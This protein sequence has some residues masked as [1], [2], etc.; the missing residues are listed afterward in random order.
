MN[1]SIGKS[2]K[3]IGGIIFAVLVFAMVRAIFSANE[4]EE[5]ITPSTQST[6]SQAEED[7]LDTQISPPNG[8]LSLE[9]R[10]TTR[11]GVIEVQKTEQGAQVFLNG[12][13]LDLS[14][15]TVWLGPAYRYG[16]SDF[17]IARTVLDGA[18]CPIFHTLI[19]VKE[20][21]A[22]EL[23]PLGE[24]SDLIQVTERPGKLVVRVGGEAFFADASGVR[25][26]KVSDATAEE[27]AHEVDHP[28]TSLTNVLR[29]LVQPDMKMYRW[30]G[31]LERAEL[32]NP[33]A[34]AL[35]VSIGNEQYQHGFIAAS[36]GK[37]DIRTEFPSLRLNSGVC[38]TGRYLGN[39]ESSTAT[40]KT[41]AVPVL[42]IF[43]L[44]N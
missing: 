42:T 9:E 19:N 39:Q 11:F 28:S 27:A 41:I 8:D 20:A 1:K 3:V 15:P 13:A 33:K 25:K 12:K 26:V 31:K 22:I 18:A 10:R 24:C 21:G 36:F 29:P 7:N 38:V 14:A 34:Q 44:S 43:R 30:C 35:L 6:T 2:A 16:S 5:G 32:D 37:F 4:Q 40:G 17:L 23:S